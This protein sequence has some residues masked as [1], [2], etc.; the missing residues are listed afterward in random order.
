MKFHVRMC[1]YIAQD[2]PGLQENSKIQNLNFVNIGN[3]TQ[4]LVV[5]CVEQTPQPLDYKRLKNED[6]ICKYK[7]ELPSSCQSP[8]RKR[9]NDYSRFLL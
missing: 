6:Q 8:G 9:P 2:V 7:L 5:V 3:R 1:L 4:Y